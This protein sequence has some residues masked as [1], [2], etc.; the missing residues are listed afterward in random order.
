MSLAEI[1]T[2][3]DR[4]LEDH[5]ALRRDLAEAS[6]LARCHVADPLLVTVETLASELLEHMQKEERVLLP[7]IRAGRGATAVA[8]IRAM[9]REHDQTLAWVARLRELTNGYHA[10]TEPLA[11]LYALLDGIDRF[12]VEHIALEND[13]L[14]PQA[15]CS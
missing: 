13:V 3:V 6:R 8:P 11:E 2:L 12:L 1:G 9:S 5:A 15:L 14:F 7:W 10:P 4:V